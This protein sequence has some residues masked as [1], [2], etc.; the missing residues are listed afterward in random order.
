[1]T[2]NDMAH[3]CQEKGST[4]TNACYSQMPAEELK[5]AIRTKLGGSLF[6]GVVLL[7]D[8]DHPSSAADTAETPQKICSEVLHRRPYRPCL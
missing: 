8:N 4:I 6:K 5:P 2:V 1:M 3:H 7:H